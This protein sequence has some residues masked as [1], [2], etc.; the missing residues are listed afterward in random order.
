MQISISKN[1]NNNFAKFAKREI[2]STMIII[3]NN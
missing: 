2:A 3:S 1:L